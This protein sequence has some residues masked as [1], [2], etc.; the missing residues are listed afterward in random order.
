MHDYSDMEKEAMFGAAQKVIMANAK[1][2][3]AN[4][5]TMAKIQ[6]KIMGASLTMQSKMLD[7]AVVTAMAGGSVGQFGASMASQAVA[8]GLQHVAP[9]KFTNHIGTAMD[10]LT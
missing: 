10:I 2:L 9:G 6:N 5:Q 3:M 7:P 1:K 4:P 8:K